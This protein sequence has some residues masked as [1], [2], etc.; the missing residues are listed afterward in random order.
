MYDIVMTVYSHF[1][2]CS[3]T[4]CTDALLLNDEKCP[5]FYYWYYVRIYSVHLYQVRIYTCID[6]AAIIMTTLQIIH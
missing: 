5:A 1:G 6:T 2:N 4:C 3:V